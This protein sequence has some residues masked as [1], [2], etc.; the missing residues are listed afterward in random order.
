MGV[1]AL[2]EIAVVFAEESTGVV[3]WRVDNDEAVVVA[4]LADILECSDYVEFPTGEL[5]VGEAFEEDGVFRHGGA[6]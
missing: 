4:V 6:G 3:V 2:V 5:T 1:D